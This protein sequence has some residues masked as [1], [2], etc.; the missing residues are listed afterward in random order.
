[1]D[2]DVLLFAERYMLSC[3]FFF[4]ISYHRAFY[5]SHFYFGLISLLWHRFLN[6]MIDNLLDFMFCA[7]GI[8]HLS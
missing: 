2:F 6:G 3:I 8:S 1:M 5:A 4:Y 7:L